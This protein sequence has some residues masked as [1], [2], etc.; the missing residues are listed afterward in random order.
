MYGIPVPHSASV[1]VPIPLPPSL[2]L[3]AS[4]PHRRG[5]LHLTQ[6]RRAPEQ[7]KDVLAATPVHI[8]RR[9]GRERDAEDG[10]V[11]VR[12]PLR[13]RGAQ[14]TGPRREL[15]RL[16][17]VQLEGVVGE[18]EDEQRRR[19]RREGEGVRGLGKGRE[20]RVVPHRVEVEDVRAHVVVCRRE[21]LAVRAYGHACDRGRHGLCVGGPGVGDISALTVEFL[22]VQLGF[23]LIRFTI[24]VV[25]SPS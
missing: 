13:E 12:E 3:K 10:V 4:P 16:D 2:F 24:F 15:A 23:G 8:F 17:V 7:R 22:D 19:A 9:H 25:S 21:P 6:P 18:A 20:G 14:R 11:Q 5:E 1:D